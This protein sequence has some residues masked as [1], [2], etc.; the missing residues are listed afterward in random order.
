V[1]FTE[2]KL[3]GAYVIELEKRGDARGFFARAFCQHEFAANGLMTVVAQTNLS[4]SQSAGTLR[5]MHYQSAPYAEAKLVRCTRGSLYD[6]IIDLRP[7]SATY[8]SWLGVE[9][10]TDNRRMLYVPE[11]FAHGF[12]TLEDA[13][14]VTYQ[15]SQ[16]YTP[17]AERGVR[18]D[19]P[20]FGIEWP[21]TPKVISDK[22]KRWPDYAG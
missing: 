3:P 9:L 11:G 8:R 18:W 17:E 14:E 2:T 13:V 1:I 10:N 19:D 16:F 15:V 12:I 22:D 21:L 6:V 4:F 5:G 20:A 7:A